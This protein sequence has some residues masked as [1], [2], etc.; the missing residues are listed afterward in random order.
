VRNPAVLYGGDLTGRILL[1]YLLLAPCGA[2]F[3]IDAHRRR[4]ALARERLAR[5]ETPTRSGPV[6]GPGWPVRLLQIQIAI[7]YLM[8]G[9]SKAQGTDYHDGTAL[10]YALANPVYS[11]FHGIAAPLFVAMAPV[12]ALLTHIT[13]WW[14]LAFAFMLPF[15]RLRTVALVIGLFVHGGIF[16]LMTIEWWG[17]LMILSYLAFVPGRALDR[18]WMRQV[19]QARRARWPDRLRLEFDPGN[20]D[21]VRWV[22]AIA[23]TDCFRLVHVVPAP[24]LASRWRLTRRADGAAADTA[25]L[26]RVLPL[27]ARLTVRDAP[28]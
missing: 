1:F 21:V 3:S 10:G 28:A 14:E 16:V 11:R 5:G 2:A 18:V 4:R 20:P 25:A 22:A 12:L 19:R 15:R 8:T 7:T 26:R 17:P 23:T 13:L 27:W 6:L 24:D 9:F